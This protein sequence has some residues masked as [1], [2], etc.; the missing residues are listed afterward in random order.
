MKLLCDCDIVITNPPFSLFRDFIKLCVTYNTKFLILGNQNTVVAKDIFPLFIENKIWYGVT[1]RS[2]GMFFYIKKSMPRFSKN[3]KFKND[4]PYIHLGCIKW[5]TNLN[6]DFIPEKIPLVK[7]YNSIE[8]PK[9]DTYDAIEVNKTKNIPCDYDGV[10]GVPLTFLSRYNPDQFEI[11]GV[12]SHG[13]DNKYDLAKPIIN[14]KEK[15]KRIAIKR[16]K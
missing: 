9:Y 2:G 4:I 16:K 7:K 3:V 14:G 11:V 6:H 8:Y 10:M 1:V 5:L 15:Y 12:F 13:C